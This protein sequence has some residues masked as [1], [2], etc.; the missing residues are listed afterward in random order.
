MKLSEQTLACLWMAVAFQSLV[1]FVAA[2]RDFYDLLGIS[3]SATDRQIKKAFRKL[4][5]QYHPDKNKEKGAEDKFREIAEA[6]DVLSDED[7]RK[8]YDMYGHQAFSDGGSGHASGHGFEGQQGFNFNDF[9]K[10][11]DEQFQSH[12]GHFSNEGQGGHYQH[13]SNYHSGH[14]SAN[15]AQAH[16][17]RQQQQRQAGFGGHFGFDFDGLFNDMD[18]DEYNFIRSGRPHHQ[19]APGFG[20]EAH[21]FGGGDSFFGNHF[22]GQDMGSFGFAS[23]GSGS[24]CHTVTKRMGNTVMTYAE[25]S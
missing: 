1:T 11:F 18:S 17:H 23:A 22:G 7:K 25:C 16:H 13:N 9:F 14:G 5:L 12:E 8:K 4:A 3:R 21:A 19:A 6:Y 15:H 10:Q 24:N 20:H 2:K